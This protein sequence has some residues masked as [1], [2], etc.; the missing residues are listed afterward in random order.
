MAIDVNYV[1]DVSKPSDFDS[2]WDEVLGELDAIELNP[3]CEKDEL[4]SDT[5]V[6]V[7]QA[8]YDSLDGL[9]VSAWY[10]KPRNSS[11]KLP[12][13]ILMP[14]YQSDPPIPKEW[15][16]KGYACISVNPRGKVRSR[17]QFDP[18]YPGLLTYGI[19]D[20]NIY[21]YR[22]FYADAWRAV[23][24]LLS[25]PDVDSSRIGVAGSSQGGGLTIVT[26]AFRKEIKAA[27]AG[28]PYLC[29]FK[30]AIKLTDSYPYQEINDYINYFKGVDNQVFETL[31]Y[32]DGIN[33]AHKIDCP[34]VMNIGLRDNVCPPETGYSLF[35]QIKS[36]NKK[37]Y[38]YEDHGHDAGRIHHSNVIDEFFEQNIKLI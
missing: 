22:G 10:A 5:D 14:G 24:F 20:R 25:R 6:E 12:A 28:A 13:I 11:Q 38:E 27:S 31:Q 2:F 3:I 36:V 8:Y 16:R 30:D 18:G 23:D 17:L 21:S 19:L 32:F 29:G 4:R 7:F 15:A 1:C 35:N 34:I 37:L 9:R 33:F 26:S